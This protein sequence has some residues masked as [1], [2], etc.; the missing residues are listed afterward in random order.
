VKVFAHLKATRA[1]RRKHLGFLQTGEDHAI[2][3]EIGFHEENGAPLTLKRLQ[4][5]GL[6][7]VPTLQRRLRRLRQLG[8]VVARRS[9]RDARAVELLLSARVHRAY[10]RYGE[11]IGLNGARRSSVEESSA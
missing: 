3:Q 5:T 2:V 8:I 1:F 7:S 11:L 4:L 6:T 10:A 9:A